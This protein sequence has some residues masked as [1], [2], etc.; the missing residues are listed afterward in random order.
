MRPGDLEG[1]WPLSWSPPRAAP[2][3]AAGDYVGA[4]PLG[5][6]RDSR[7]LMACHPSDTRVSLPTIA[8]RPGLVLLV[9]SECRVSADRD[10]R[11]GESQGSESTP[12][13]VLVRGPAA[14]R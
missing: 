8:T 9:S 2:F 11:R 13:L 12:A 3:A 1:F 4:I 6:A 10:E 14:L 5:A 7:E